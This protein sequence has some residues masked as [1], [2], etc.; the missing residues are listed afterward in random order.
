LKVENIRT[1]LHWYVYRRF[2][3]FQRLNDKLRLRYPHLDYLSLPSKSIFDMNVFNPVF[4]EKRQLGLQLY[5]NQLMSNKILLKESSVRQFLC[6][7][8]PPISTINAP[9]ND[10]LTYQSSTY[11]DSCDQLFNC[12]NCFLLEKKIDELQSILDKKDETIKRLEN[13]LRMRSD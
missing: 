1:G 4:I 9:T 6:I 5:L 12:N 11:S 7:D 13:E 8:E 2:T 3:D 10:T